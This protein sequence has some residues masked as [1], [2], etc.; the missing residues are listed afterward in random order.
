M[1]GSSNGNVPAPD[2][3]SAVLSRYPNIL[4]ENYLPPRLSWWQKVWFVCA[5][6]MIVLPAIFLAVICIRALLGTAPP[7][8]S[9]WTYV[10]LSLFLVG[11]V[12]E[13]LLRHRYRVHQAQTEDRSEIEAL[14]QEGKN[15]PDRDVAANGG[16]ETKVQ[17][18]EVLRRQVGDEIRRLEELSPPAWTFY[19]VL[20]LHQLLIDFLTVDDLKARARSVLVELEDYAEGNAVSYD[21]RL[22]NQWKTTI[23]NDIDAI[24]HSQDHHD[25]I[26]TLRADLRSLL[27]HLASYESN[28]ARGK[29]IVNG[30]RICGSVAVVVLVLMGLL[31]VIYPVSQTAS[32]YSPSIGILHWGLLGSAGALTSAL[33]G[34]RD[35]NEVEIGNTRGV[36]ELW[37]TVLG[38]VLGF[39]AG[40]LIFSALA[41][42]LIKTGTAVPE[43]AQ[44]QLRDVYL[45]IAWAV[46]A[47]MA[48]QT[49][50]QRV[51]K[52]IES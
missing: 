37:R 10:A 4:P 52:V 17:E 30:I 14:L 47:G 32:G 50:F 11:L 43:L 9:C 41:A 12:W 27:E 2:E 42:Q 22:Y 23:N 19:Q 21:A 6:G 8:C 18:L 40:I 33:I 29:T 44:M 13:R 24:N 25:M 5:L 26:S 3:N 34:L 7:E 31:E 49:V 45:S 15:L 28:W 20:T 51:G 39:V 16:T 35:T 1:A 48:F 46:V 36:Q 38:A